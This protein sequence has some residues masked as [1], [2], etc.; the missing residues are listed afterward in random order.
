MLSATSTQYTKG[1]IIIILRQNAGI[2]DDAQAGLSHKELIVLDLGYNIQLHTPEL[3]ETQYT[4]V[5]SR[6]GNPLINEHRCSHV[7]TCLKIAFGFEHHMDK[8][9]TIVLQT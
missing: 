4:L 8:C 1:S 6:D 7:V 9:N 2:D 3:T 5:L